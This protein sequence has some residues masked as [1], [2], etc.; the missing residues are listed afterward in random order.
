MTYKLL[1]M[2][3]GNYQTLTN[4]DTKTSTTLGMYIYPKKDCSLYSLYSI[5]I[6]KNISLY[7]SFIQSK[8]IQN[9]ISGPNKSD[10]NTIWANWPHQ[11]FETEIL[12]TSFILLLYTGSSPDALTPHYECYG[13]WCIS[14]SPKRYPTGAAWR[15]DYPILVFVC[16][17]AIYHHVLQMTCGLMRNREYWI[18]LHQISCDVVQSYNLF[19]HIFSHYFFYTNTILC[20]LNPSNKVK[21][22]WHHRYPINCSYISEDFCHLWVMLHSSRLKCTG[23][24]CWFITN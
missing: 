1:A 9:C 6:L 3:Y 10:Y 19:V 22:N 5:S 24:V 7:N 20:T 17:W 15:G 2:K 21:L 8:L 12:S 16:A 23:L 13:Y 4:K 14:L 11:W 18:S